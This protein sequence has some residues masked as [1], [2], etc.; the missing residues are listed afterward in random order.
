M[1]SL[2]LSSLYTKASPYQAIISTHRK[3][4]PIRIWLLNFTPLKQ[5]QTRDTHG[6]RTLKTNFIEIISHTF[7]DYTIRK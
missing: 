2:N 7:I 5:R 3:Y 6:K 1:F 4:T